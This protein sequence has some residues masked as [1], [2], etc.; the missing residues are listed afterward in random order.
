MD[1]IKRNIIKK[2]HHS[3][4]NCGVEYSI[5]TAYRLIS[6]KY[7]VSSKELRRFRVI[8]CKGF[9]DFL[10]LEGILVPFIQETEKFRKYDCSNFNQYLK[11]E[12]ITHFVIE[13]FSWG[14]NEYKSD[15]E[16]WRRIHYK[17]KD[18]L[19]GRVLLD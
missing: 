11:K 9:M 5:D 2:L 16:Y 1:S 8:V 18:I 3:F 17:W 6:L 19:E 15:D 13:A 7:G 12:K 4:G 10:K 14:F